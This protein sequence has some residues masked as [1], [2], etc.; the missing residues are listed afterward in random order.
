M[1]LGGGSLLG[2]V[3]VWDFDLENLSSYVKHVEGEEGQY[4]MG[5]E[6]VMGKLTSLSGHRVS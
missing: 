1:R 2:T 5:E 6:R 3:L 4:R